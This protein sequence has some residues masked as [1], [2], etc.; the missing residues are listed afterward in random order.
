M[1][2]SYLPEYKGNFNI[3]EI[4]RAIPGESDAA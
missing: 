3:L 1:I 4:A 2:R